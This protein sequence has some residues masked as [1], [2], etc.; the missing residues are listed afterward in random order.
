MKYIDQ[1]QFV[2]VHRRKYSLHMY[3]FLKLLLKFSKLFVQ[4][5]R[6]VTSDTM[7]LKYIYI[8]KDDSNTFRRYLKYFEHVTSICRQ[9][10]AWCCFVLS[11]NKPNLKC[12]F[13]KCTKNEKFACH[14]TLEC[15][16]L[17]FSF[18]VYCF[19]ILQPHQWFVRS[20]MTTRTVSI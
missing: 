20:N 8:S 18:Q 7:T 5:I 12:W 6:Q 10:K 2:C 15:G 14:T 9:S 4:S 3:I 17:E 13:K 1:K 11:R 19:K 16:E